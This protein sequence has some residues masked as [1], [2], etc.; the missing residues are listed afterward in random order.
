MYLAAQDLPVRLDAPPGV[1][2]YPPGATY[3]PRT[4][5]DFELVW[6]LHG[7]ATWRCDD[8]REQVVPG[9]LLLLRP[10]M[11]D[12]FAWDP[13][14]P[15]RHA[16][17][18]FSLARDVAGSDSWPLRRDLAYDD[19]LAGL[20]RH[21]LWLCSTRSAHWDSRT[22]D[23][24]SLLLASYATGPLPEPGDVAPLPA[25]LEAV[26]EVLREEWAAGP[27][28]PVTPARLAAAAAVST[29][30]LSRTFHTRFGLGPAKAVE[31][32]RLS[33]AEDLLLRSNLTLAAI[34]TECGFADAYHFSRRFRAT[35]ATPPGRFRTAGPQSAPPSPLARTGLLPLH[36][37]IWQLD[38][39]T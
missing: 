1:V 15:T 28:R 17:V 21:M 36:H 19:V 39:V 38:D 10:G 9:S 2:D 22:E 35:Y 3:G 34:A 31:L 29:S 11:T 14:R 20:F 27:L 33:R 8:R 12:E 13:E 7:S 4:L 16:Y 30:H 37:R 26:I 23:V 32:L 24:L 6:L 5:A 25:V 18:H